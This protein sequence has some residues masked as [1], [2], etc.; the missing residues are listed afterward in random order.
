MCI[1]IY[2]YIK[3]IMKG[4][5]GARGRGGRALE[6]LLRPISTPRNAS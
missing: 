6:D 4:A 5:P 1:Y 2:I 3:L